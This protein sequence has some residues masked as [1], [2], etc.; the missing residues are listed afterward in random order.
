MPP[1][2]FTATVRA[3]VIADAAVAVTVTVVADALSLTLAGLTDSVT[4]GLMS[5]SARVT[6]A[7]VTVVFR[8]VPATPMVSFPSLVVSCVGVRVKVPVPLVAFAAILMSKFD[9]AA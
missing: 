2:T 1:P 9:T 5:S 4:A 7:P 8:L 3:E 6:V